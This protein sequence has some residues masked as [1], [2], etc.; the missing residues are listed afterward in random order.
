M[1]IGRFAPSPTGELHFGSLVAA[2]AS[3]LDARSHNGQ[4]LLR[5]DDIDPPREK[6]GAAQAIIETLKAFGLDWDDEIVFQS[7]RYSLYQKALEQLR[8]KHLSYPC[9]CSRKDIFKRTN[10]NYYDQ[11]CL[12]N[13]PSDVLKCA[14]RFK[15]ITQT[16]NWTDGLLG[17]QTARSADFV[18]F[19]IKRSDALW[20]YQLAVT[21]DDAAMGITHIVRGSD[22]LSEATKQQT[23]I[24]ALGLPEINFSHIPLVRNRSGQKLSKQNQAPALTTDNVSGTLLA[25]LEILGQQPKPSLKYADKRDILQQAISDWNP[26]SIPLEYPINN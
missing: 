3:Y 9:N 23:L 2:L 10:S 22:L 19:I 21:V 20:A 14:W 17:E 6:P 16:N 15:N 24:N 8:D 13:I 4:W 11:H 25:A 18:D 12:S 7:T 1:Y 5:I 26:N